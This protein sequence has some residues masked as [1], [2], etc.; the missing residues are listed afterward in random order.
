MPSSGWQ[1]WKNWVGYEPGRM[2]A[3]GLLH[4]PFGTR[5]AVIAGK[6]TNCVET[7]RQNLGAKTNRFE[8]KLLFGSASLLLCEL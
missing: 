4:E 3:V 8:N 1:L 7:N 5:V 6:L 2:L